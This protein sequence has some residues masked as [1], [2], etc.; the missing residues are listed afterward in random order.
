MTVENFYSLKSAASILD[1]STK[2][3]RR[4]IESEEI[5]VYKVGRR[6]RL[7]ETQLISMAKRQK[8]AKAIVEDL[9]KT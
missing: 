5:E 9:L 7:S 8:P 1:I 3:L 6:L 2:T 4:I